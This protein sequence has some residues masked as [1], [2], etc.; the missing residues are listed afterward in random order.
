MQRM[1]SGLINCVP[2]LQQGRYAQ[3]FSMISNRIATKAERKYLRVQ[4]NESSAAFPIEDEKALF[5]YKQ[6][7]FFYMQLNICDTILANS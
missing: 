7:I 3:C 5:I 2:P 4:L 6:N 1:L